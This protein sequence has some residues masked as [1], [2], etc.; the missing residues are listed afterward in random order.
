MP[1]DLLKRSPDIE[2]MIPYWDMVTD[3]IEGEEAIKAGGVKYLPK[4]PE[5]NDNDYSFRVEV[6]KFTNIY[7]DTLEGLATK[8]F[9][10]E[11]SVVG[12]S[13]DPKI[14][15]FV[16]DVDGCGNNLTAFSALTFFN[17]IN[18]AI[19]WIFVDYPTITDADRLSI[20]QAKEQHIRAYWRHILGKNVLE[21]HSHMEGSKEIV[22]Y[23]RYQEPSYGNEPVKVRVYAEEYDGFGKKHIMWHL[24]RKVDNPKDEDEEFIEIDK[25]EM[26]IGFIPV[27]PF[28]TGRRDGNR[29]KFYPVMKDA[30]TLQIKLYQNE[31]ALEYIKVLACYPMLATDGLKPKLDG[32]GSPEK[33]AVG[34]GR[35][36]YGAPNTNGTGGT[37]KY[38]E[39]S[40]N[41]L[42]FLK[43]DIDKT[44]TDLRELGRQPLTALSSQL[45]T[46]TTSIAAGKAKSAVTTWALAL[47]DALEN[48]LYITMLWEQKQ[49][50]DNKQPE[51]YVYTGFDNVLE[52]GSDLEELG[53]ARERG[54]LSQ[55]TY[56]EE[57][58]RRKILSAEFTA[59][60][61]KKRLLEDIPTDEVDLSE[62]EAPTTE[63]KDIEK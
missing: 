59:E 28:I 63:E 18:Y 52:D 23:F 31:S 5:E 21:V 41:S 26:S 35:V 57:L 32:K 14:K 42:E 6:G 10:D 44:K 54:D 17:G 25:G 9:Q 62:D 58:K 12:E 19:D 2:T 1:K 16:E 39:P 33:I 56:W 24:Y 50:P 45:T 22:D 13:V 3:I 53:K 43:K 7:R 30:A 20:A 61:E 49:V 36:L 29:F 27:V 8:P 4:F 47:K 48:A 55:E 60:R 38:V 51:V 11:V 37:W 40:A 46:V 15:E 34:P